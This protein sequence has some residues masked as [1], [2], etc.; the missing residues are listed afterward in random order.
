MQLIPWLP[1]AVVALAVSLFFG[2]GPGAVRRRERGLRGAI[3][4][5]GHAAVWALLALAAVTLAFGPPASSLAGPL[6]LA[7]LACYLAF[8]GALLGSRRA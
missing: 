1:L 6:G 2:V 8:L 4:R 5:W 3:V 7:A